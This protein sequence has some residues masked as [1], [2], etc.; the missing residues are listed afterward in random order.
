MTRRTQRVASLI[1]ETVGQV[2]LTSLSDPR[3]DPA[4]TS[5]THVDVPEDLM[6]AKVYVSVLG[7]EAE[8]RSAVRALNHAAGHI[9][10]LM[11]ARISLRH[12]PRLRFQLDEDFRKTL[13]TYEI[14]GQAM[15]EIRDKQQDREAAGPPR[16]D[17]SAGT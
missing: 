1:R 16:R 7:S 6:T 9:Q 13:E 10:E 15:Q 11:M 14:I 8:Q 5:I 12:T 17:P 4:R 2:V 3:I